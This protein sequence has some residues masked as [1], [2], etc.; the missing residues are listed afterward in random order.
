METIDSLAEDDQALKKILLGII[1]LVIVR[2]VVERIR[3][4]QLSSELPGPPLSFSNKE[5]VHPFLAHFYPLIMSVGSISKFPD[6]PNALWWYL[7]VGNSFAEYGICHL[8]AFHPYWVPFAR[9]SNFIFDGGIAKQLLEDRNNAGKL[10]KAKRVYDIAGPLVGDSLLSLPDGPEWKHQRK[11]AAASFGQRFLEHL[12]EISVHILETQVFPRWQSTSGNHEA[13]PVEAQGVSSRLTLE[14]LGHV[15]F[16]YTFGSFREETADGEG[17]S[18][19]DC[20]TGM[21]GYCTRRNRSPPYVHLLWRKENATFQKNSERLNKAVREVVQRRLDEQLKMEQEKSSSD[22]P[23]TST[24]AP[25]DLLDYLVLKD[26]DGNRMPFDYIFGNVRMFFFAGHETTAG[27]L[28]NGLWQLATHP[29]QQQQLQAEVDEL[30]DGLEKNDTS[31]S[32]FPTHKQLNQLRYLDAVARECLRMYS[33]AIV[34]RTSTEPILLTAR[35]GRTYNFPAGSNFFVLPF[36]GHMCEAYWENATE[37]SPE[38][39]L[40]SNGAGT[41]SGDWIP[42]SVGAR[43]CVGQPMAVAELKCLLAH[44]FRNYTIRPQ[45][46]AQ[47][48]IN[49]ILLTV[50]PLEVPILVERR[51]HS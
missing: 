15:A 11:R 24:P 9:C 20:Y 51:Q 26:D 21:L 25:K 22:G 18:L 17:E 40:A 44:I 45:E 42:F 39:F 47:P 29:E 48:P 23:A 10:I 14:I 32:S 38:R 7:K 12:C 35:N 50:K 3:V 4:I 31:A 30:Y 6:Y 16:G 19:Y 36:I 49:T 13:V 41:K 1:T 8:W 34:G 2:K 33:P 43:N 5:W 46:G 28:A 27:T 37:F